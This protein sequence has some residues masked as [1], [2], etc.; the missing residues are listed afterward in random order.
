MYIYIYMYVYMYVY[1]YIYIYGGFRVERL[2]S[3]KGEYIE[4]YT[5]EYY[6]GCQG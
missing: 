5:G 3:L 6:K 2:N 1:I 4:D